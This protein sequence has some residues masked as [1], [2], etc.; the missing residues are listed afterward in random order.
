M[1]TLLTVVRTGRAQVF[2]AL[3]A[4]ATYDVRIRDAANSACV[5]ILNNGLTI[6]EPSVIT[7][8]VSSSNVTCNGANDGTI[9]ISSPTGGYGTYEYSNDGGTTWQA[10]GNFTNL[11]P[12]SYN[13]QIRDKAH[14][15]CVVVLDAALVITEPA[16]LN[17]TVNSTDVTCNGANNGTITISG[18]SGGYGTYAY[19]VNGGASWQSS[20]NFTN[21]A[22]GTYNVRM[23]DAANIACVLTLNA[24]LVITEPPVLN[25]T[26]DHSN[27]TCSGTG[28][29]SITI[30]D[31]LGGYGTFEYTINGGTILAGIRQLYCPDPGIL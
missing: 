23:R 9:T 4:P 3:L 24:A 26:V 2:S 28:D 25:A 20:G 27:V 12:A 17:A 31:P 6:T 11:A 15:T 29:G 18:A 22:P 10:S 1:N 8:N 14:I 13:V 19:T 21:L 7:A 16:A 5:I 30:T